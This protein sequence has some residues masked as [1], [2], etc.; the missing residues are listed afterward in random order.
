MSRKCSHSSIMFNIIRYNELVCIPYTCLNIYWFMKLLSMIFTTVML[1][2]QFLVLIEVYG[3]Q[4]IE[5]IEILW[6]L[7]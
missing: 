5:K 4:S 6:N 1:I 2:I 3:L 7:K